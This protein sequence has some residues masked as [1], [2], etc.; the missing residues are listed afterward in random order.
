MLAC[1][2]RLK[3]Q[4][5]VEDIAQFG[6]DPSRITLMGQGVGAGSLR[7]LSCLAVPGARQPATVPADRNCSLQTFCLSQQKREGV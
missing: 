2:R 5:V 6:G 7:Q 4:W 1:L 3:L